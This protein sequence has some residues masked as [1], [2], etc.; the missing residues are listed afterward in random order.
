[1]S[2]IRKLESLNKEEALDALQNAYGIYARDVYKGLSEE[3]RADKDITLS[4]VQKSG[5][6]LE[7]SSEALRDDKEVVMYAVSRQGEALIHASDRL[8]ADKEV[9]KTAVNRNGH[10][11]EHASFYSNKHSS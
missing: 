11:L 6:S 10:A 9:V 1:M 7:Y 8:K 4:A 5:W 3:L 2:N